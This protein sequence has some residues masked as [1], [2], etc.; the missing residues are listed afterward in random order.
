MITTIIKTQLH[1]AQVKSPVY[2]VPMYQTY[3]IGIVKNKTEDL[4][5]TTPSLHHI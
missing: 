1:N 5:P 4:I 3:E 2:I